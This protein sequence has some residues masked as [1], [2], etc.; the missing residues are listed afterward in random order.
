MSIQKTTS[1]SKSLLFR[2]IFSNYI[3]TFSGIAIAFVLT[4]YVVHTLGDTRYG[5]W[6]ILVALTGYM[7]V[8]DLGVSS[9]IIKFVAR[10]RAQQDTQAVNEFV[11][12]A[13][14]VYIVIALVILLLTPLLAYGVT[15]YIEFEDEL[16][17]TVYLLVVITSVNMAFTTLRG[18]FKGTLVGLQRHDIVNAL[19]ISQGLFTSALIFLVLYMGYGLLA[20]SIVAI[21]T[22]LLLIASLI[23]FTRKYFPEI[24]IKLS[25][26]KLATAKSAVNFGK[27][28]FLSMLANQ[29][30]YFSDV[31]IVGFFLSAAAVAYYTIASTLAQ[32]TQQLVIGICSSFLPYFSG[33]QA[34][35]DSGELVR[36]YLMGTKIVIAVSNLFCVGIFILGSYFIEIW[37]SE[38]YA[39]ISTPIL[40]I[41]ITI[42]IVK[43]PQSLSYSLLQ[44][45]GKHKVYSY[46]QTV[47]SV[48]NLVLSI[49]LVKAYGLLGVAAA[50]AIT[51]ITFHG[52]VVPILTFKFLKIDAIDFLSKTYVAALFP[53]ALLALVLYLSVSWK[54]PDG[55]L[56]LFAQ[57]GL[58][59]LVYAVAYFYCVLDPD[60]QKYLHEKMPFSRGTQ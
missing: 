37:L 33:V 48:S 24:Q 34:S 54:E 25:L 22:Q 56:L 49:I 45:L 38:I 31:L 41:L 21:S 55:Y 1:P 4:P 29:M 57:A 15:H 2:G 60:E 16:K 17:D 58:A 47:F 30:V 27:F 18:L 40:L 5:I 32:Y 39:A 35:D 28:T 53:S 36:S 11:S 42:Q 26:A 6:T 52:V 8:L 51:Q 23:Y 20:M 10:Y 3:A 14:A 19:K 46:W 44:G 59:A 50:T 7:M 43:G 12:S 9:A 13:F